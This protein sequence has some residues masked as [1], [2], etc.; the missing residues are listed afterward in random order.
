MCPACLRGTLWPLAL[1]VSAGRTPI[2]AAGS[3][4]VTAG[5]FVRSLL[6]EQVTITS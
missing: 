4:P 1:M 6:I 2:M 3:K 5:G